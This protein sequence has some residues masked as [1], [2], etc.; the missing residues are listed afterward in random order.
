MPNLPDLSLTPAGRALPPANQ[1]GL[2][3]LSVGFNFG[4]G[5]A[6]DS[7]DTL[8]GID[9][10][11]FDTFAFLTALAT[12]PSAFGFANADT[13][14]LTGNIGTGGIVCA[15][16]NVHVFWDSVH[17]TAAAHQVLGNAFA[18]AVPEPAGM[19]L[20]LLGLGFGVARRVLGPRRRY[21]R[22]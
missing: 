5:A 19:T 22:S 8:P 1:A 16:P 11:R 2:K 6:L 9:I 13:A 3:A 4:L 20:L 14:C 12:N 10:T 21:G 7:L 15:D 18:A 17:P